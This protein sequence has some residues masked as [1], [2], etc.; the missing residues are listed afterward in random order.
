[1]STATSDRLDIWFDLDGVMVKFHEALYA[2]GRKQGLNYD[3]ETNP[4]PIFT[5]Y[6][7]HDQMVREGEFLRMSPYEDS[8]VVAETLDKMGHRIHYMTARASCTDDPKVTAILER[9]TREWLVSNG[10]PAVKNLV[11]SGREHKSR[12]LM[13]RQADLLVEDHAE[14]CQDTA[15]ISDKRGLAVMALLMDR[16]WNR[17]AS[18]SPRMQ[19][20]FQ[21]FDFLRTVQAYPSLRSQLRT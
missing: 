19:S 16:P 7:L 12:L 2:F 14:T 18:Y 11:I 4:M 21:V 9:H 20:M 1:M 10:F 15:K 17:G 5:A 3:I 13:Q 6:P 8:L